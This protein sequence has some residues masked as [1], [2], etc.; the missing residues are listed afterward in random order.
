[1]HSTASQTT[2]NNIIC[3]GIGPGDLGLLTRRGAELIA[4]ADVVAGFT[5]VVDFA[6][7]LITPESVVV[8]MGY[9]DQ[10]ERL[11]EVAVMVHEGKSCVVLFMGDI[12]FS[13]FQYLA[14]VEAAVGHPVPTLPG[15][16]SSQVLA[17][18]AKV[19][20]DETTFITFH[21]RGDIEPFKHHLL[22]ALQDGRN[23]IVIPLPWSFMPAEIAAWLVENGLSETHRVE[24]WENLTGDEASWSG[25]LADCT[26]EFS[27]F[28]IMLVRALI[29]FP[30]G[31]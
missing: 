2:Q 19:C 12:H 25:T 18:K 22:H 26:A 9:R 13:G 27:H 6:R 16:S 24:V 29:P 30:V 4:S 23:A 28:S 8:T 15:I 3:I 1:M 14:R 11:E 10:T 31:I 21:R 7:E 20:F 5:T 17:S